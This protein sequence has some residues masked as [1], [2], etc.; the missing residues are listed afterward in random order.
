MPT[1][2]STTP[3]CVAGCQWE[4]ELGCAATQHRQPRQWRPRRQ[5]ISRPEHASPPPHLLQGPWDQAAAAAGDRFD[6]VVDTIGGSYEPAS[7]RLLKPGGHFSALGASGP[8]VKSVSMWGIAAMLL[9]A[10]RRYVAGRLRLGPR[11]LL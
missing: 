8:G 7:L 6:L 3:R 9:N 4:E 10:L 11:Y 1:W 5:R 2:R